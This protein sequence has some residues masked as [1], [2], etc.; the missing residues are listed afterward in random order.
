LR[1]QLDTHNPTALTPGDS[2]WGS[3][4]VTRQTFSVGT[5]LRFSARVRLG[6]VLP[7]GMVA[8]LFG[9][10]LNG[11]VRDEIDVELLT[12][13]RSLVLTNVFQADGFNTGG[14]PQYHGGIDAAA[15]NELSVEWLP[16]LIR[17]K[18]NG[19][20]VRELADRVPI[21]PMSIRL[22][23]WAPAA[24]FPQ[25]FNPALQPSAT[26]AGNQI[27]FYEVDWVEVRTL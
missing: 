5:G 27:Y 21:T 15:F 13:D 7:G 1:L 24:D 8:A 11:S 4:V 3:E 23:L 12:N 10:A 17:W 25:A 6:G 22:N 9:Y 26:A 16:N 2:F 19:V 20:T 18:V 14:R